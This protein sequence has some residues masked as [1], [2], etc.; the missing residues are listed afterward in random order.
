MKFFQETTE[1]QESWPNHVY[2]LDDS[3]SKLFAYVKQGTTEVIEFRKPMQFHVRGRKF[4]EVANTY[5]Y[6]IKE[7]EPASNIKTF[8]VVGSK[9]DEY[10]VSQDH[11]TWS[12]TCSGF[13]FRGDCKHIRQVA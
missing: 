9:G 7:K 3:K 6:N 4:R 11:Q 1:W 5:N 8:K 13:K 12:C 2:L 10:M